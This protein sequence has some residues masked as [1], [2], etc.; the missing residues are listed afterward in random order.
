MRQL[1]SDHDRVPD[2]FAPHRQPY[3]NRQPFVP[4]HHPHTNPH[5]RGPMPRQMF[6]NQMPMPPYHP[7][8][9][10]RPA[11]NPVNFAAQAL[12]QQQLMNQAARA[13]LLAQASLLQQQPQVE[14][15]SLLF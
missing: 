2:Q 6:P 15:I 5:Q 10:Q 4:P 12:V 14:R 3:S 13:R 1:L 7:H 11:F 8:Q 9:Q